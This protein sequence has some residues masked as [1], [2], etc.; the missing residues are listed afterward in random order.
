M[1]K[2]N[3][4]EGLINQ[5]VEKILQEVNPD[6]IIIFGSSVRENNTKGS[7]IDI[8]LLGVKEARISLLKDKLNEEANTLKDI[9]LILFDT[10]KNERLKDRILKEGVVIYERSS[11]K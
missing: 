10:L 1:N 11:K 8:A 5:L 6:K 9:D 7:D 3:L 2:L 4:P